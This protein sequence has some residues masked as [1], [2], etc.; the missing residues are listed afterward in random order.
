MGSY[1]YATTVATSDQ[2]IQTRS[3]HASD[4]ASGIGCLTFGIASCIVAI[5][6]LLQ[7]IVLDYFV[8]RL[9]P[10][11]AE[12]NAYDWAL[13][14]FPVL[15]AFVL[16]ALSTLRILR[17]SFGVGFSSLLVGLILAVPLIATVGIWFHFAIGGTL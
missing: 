1:P 10:Y 2:T 17:L 7:Y 3:E 9:R 5:V 14:L 12:A 8:V 15:P 4:P 16:I 13:L 6:S 11:P